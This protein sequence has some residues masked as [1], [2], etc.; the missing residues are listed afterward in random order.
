MLTKQVSISLENTLKAGYAAEVDAATLL[1]SENFGRKW[2][3]V[4]L[5]GLQ[6]TDLPIIHRMFRQ[7]GGYLDT[8]APAQPANPYAYQRRELV[9]DV[10]NGTLLNLLHLTQLS[11]VLLFGK[12]L[13]MCTINHWCYRRP[14]CHGYYHR[15]APGY[16]GGG[17]FVA[18]LS[19]VLTIAQTTWKRLHLL[20]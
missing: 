5:P 9:P 20:M 6:L 10:S 2:P 4:F 15:D 3:H 17:H 13:K 7:S 18:I 8:Y 14:A 16:P 12:W 11:K 1:R 19:Q